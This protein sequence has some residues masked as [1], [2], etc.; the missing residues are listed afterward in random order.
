M[1]CMIVRSLIVRSLTGSEG[2]KRV[3]QSGSAEKPLENPLQD[4]LG[5]VPMSLEVTISSPGAELKAACIAS[6]V[7]H[8]LFDEIP[9]G[10]SAESITRPDPVLPVILPNGQSSDMR[11]ERNAR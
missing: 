9:A 8:G 10:F 4:S 3:L 2:N 7:I 6:T 1:P 5:V 11:I